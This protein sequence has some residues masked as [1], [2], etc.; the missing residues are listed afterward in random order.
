MEEKVSGDVLWRS[1]RI[2]GSDQD[3]PRGTQHGGCLG[4]KP[5]KAN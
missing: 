4:M 3:Q 5:E 1:G 2:P